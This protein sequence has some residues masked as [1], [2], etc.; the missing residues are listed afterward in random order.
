MGESRKTAPATNQYIVLPC[1]LLHFLS[2][3]ASLQILD[4]FLVG[5]LYP[6]SDFACVM[7]VLS[8]FDTEDVAPCRMCKLACRCNFCQR[9]THTAISTTSNPNNCSS[10]A[11]YSEVYYD[12][13]V[14]V[15]DW[16]SR[17][18]AVKAH[19]HICS[20]V[21]VCQDITNASSVLPLAPGSPACGSGVQFQGIHQ[22]PSELSSVRYASSTAIT[23]EHFSFV[24]SRADV[25]FETLAVR[26]E[27]EKKKYTVSHSTKHCRCCCR[28]CSLPTRI[29][30]L[31]PPSHT[32][33]FSPTPSSPPSAA[34]S[35]SAWACASSSASSWWNSPPSLSPKSHPRRLLPREMQ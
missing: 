34:L 21:Q 22:H 13:G 11:A 16:P 20:T 18:Y 14:T 4:S 6:T 8:Q 29:V 19:C 31:F 27:L 3:P 24:L 2:P 35:A 5:I 23:L 17:S 7:D 28:C 26:Q 25:Y 15:A 9:N 30:F 33:N 32:H 1:I 12:K 10:S